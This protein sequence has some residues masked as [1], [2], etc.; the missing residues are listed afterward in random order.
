MNVMLQRHCA[1]YI[2]VIPEGLKELMTDISREVCLYI[3]LQTDAI[4]FLLYFQVIR[5]NPNN[6]Y[7]FI[8]DYLDALLVTR[9]N[10]RGKEYKRNVFFFL[11]R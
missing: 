1:R 9:E 2:Y 7:N 11:V 5:S 3:H 4:N 6:V 10:A 8:A